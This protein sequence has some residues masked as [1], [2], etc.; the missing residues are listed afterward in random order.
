MHKIHRQDTWEHGIQV[1]CGKETIGA[2]SYSE[3][4][5]LWE[6]R[7]VFFFVECY[8]REEYNTLTET[9]RLQQES[10]QHHGHNMPV[11]Y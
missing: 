1:T 4:L 6:L 11:G 3:R 2:S 5:H 10:H 9:N 7:G 8:R